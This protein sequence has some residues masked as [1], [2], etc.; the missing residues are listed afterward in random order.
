MQETNEASREYE[1]YMQVHKKM[2]YI[3]KIQKQPINS[4]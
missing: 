3:D 2:L 4:F 1:L